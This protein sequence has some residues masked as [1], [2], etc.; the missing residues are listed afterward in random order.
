M[1]K[2]ETEMVEAIKDR[3]AFRNG[4][5]VVYEANYGAMVVELYGHQIARVYHS[6]LI[7]VNLHGY[8]SKMTLSRINAIMS[9]L[10][11]GPDADKVRL[12]VKDGQPCIVCTGSRIFVPS[13]GWFDFV[14]Y[15]SKVAVVKL[16]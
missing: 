14:Y 6:G 9:G 10:L 2:L 12:A 5:T 1:H 16:G 7:D 3:E 13:S 15:A 8:T 11:V 4:P